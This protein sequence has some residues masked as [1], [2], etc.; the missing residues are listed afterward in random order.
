MTDNFTF[1]NNNNNDIKESIDINNEEVKRMTYQLEIQFA[2]I[3]GSHSAVRKLNQAINNDCSKDASLSTKMS[4]MDGQRRLIRYRVYLR[5]RRLA[6][7]NQQIQAIEDNQ[8]HVQDLLNQIED[9]KAEMADLRSMITDLDPD[10]RGRRR[11]RSPSPAPSDEQALEDMRA[12]RQALHDSLDE[13]KQHEV[14]AFISTR[15]KTCAICQDDITREE[16]TVLDCGHCFHFICAN[17]NYFY[18]RQH[19]CASCRVEQKFPP[20]TPMVTEGIIGETLDDVFGPK[21]S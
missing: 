9:K 11:R 2:K 8:Q 21:Q 18:D 3:G 16:I 4:V 5:R 20:R 15:N 7:I 19:R 13:N 12:M 10:R 14:K 6:D 1:T 17:R